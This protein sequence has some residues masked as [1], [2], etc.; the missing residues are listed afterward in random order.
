ME[1]VRDRSDIGS[2]STSGQ[3]VFYLDDD[4]AVTAATAPLLHAGLRP[5]QAP[6]PYW[7]ANRAVTFRDPDGRDVVFAPWVYGRDPDPIDVPAH[8]SWYDGDRA[9]LRPLFEEAEDSPT[10]LDQYLHAGRV[11]VARS[12]QSIVGHLQL[13]PSGRAGEIELKSM[14]V[15]PPRRRTGVGAALVTAALDA[16]RADG[17]GRIV[18]STGAAS[19]GNLSFYQRRGFRFASVERDAFT[20]DTGYPD[21]ILIEGIQ[22]LDRVWL[23]QDL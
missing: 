13:V 15:V 21:P 6:H 18:V 12:G 11:L 17:I 9:A 1:I 20:P 14:A 19:V 7:A 2:A 5:R 23:S 16:C 22:L 3:L 4:N 8:I 10:Q